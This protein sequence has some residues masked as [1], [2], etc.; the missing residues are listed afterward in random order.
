ML[1]AGCGRNVVSILPSRGRGS[2]PRAAT[3]PRPNVER[4]RPRKAE[5][6]ARSRLWRGRRPFRSRTGP[7][8]SSLLACPEH[9]PDFD[10]GFQGCYCRVVPAAAS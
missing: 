5:G 9:L 6:W 7:S 10:K 2:R 8:T 1:D 4:S 3:C